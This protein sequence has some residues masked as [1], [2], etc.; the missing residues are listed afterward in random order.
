MRMPSS[1]MKAV[2]GSTAMAPNKKWPSRWWF[3]SPVVGVNLYVL[4]LYLFFRLPFGKLN[5]PIWRVLGVPAWV[6][7]ELV[8]KPVMEALGPE[9]LEDPV[10]VW[11]IGLTLWQLA[12]V[13]L[14]LLCYGAVLL[15]Y[16]IVPGEGGEG[17]QN[18]G[19]R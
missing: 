8:G 9:V 5:L 18:D 1:R 16:A 15:V 14:G 19:S 4:T 10:T 11:A 6:F 3:W 12:A 2:K 13:V 7:S 17:K